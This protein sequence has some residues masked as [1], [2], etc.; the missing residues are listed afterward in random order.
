MLLKLITL[1]FTTTMRLYNAFL[2]QGPGSLQ[3]V[4]HAIGIKETELT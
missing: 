2:F 1:V 4:E 3:R